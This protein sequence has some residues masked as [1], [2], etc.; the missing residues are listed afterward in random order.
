MDRDDSSDRVH[1]FSHRIQREDLKAGDHIYVYRRGI[2]Y[3]HHGIYT[4]KEGDL[5]VIHFSGPIGDKFEKED[6]K[7][8]SNT[9]SEFLNGNKLRLVAYNECRT[10]ARIKKRGTSHTEKSKEAKEV[11]EDTMYYLEN[12]NDWGKYHLLSHNCESFAFICKTGKKVDDTT[13]VQSNAPCVQ[14][15]R[16]TSSLCEYFRKD[17]KEID[18]EFYE[19]PARKTLCQYLQSRGTVQ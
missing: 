19:R 14:L 18:S 8:R 1:F 2:A 12:P 11:V 9:L 5:E 7:I 17:E 16:K 6:A 15:I 13:S 4:G 3:Q 10:N